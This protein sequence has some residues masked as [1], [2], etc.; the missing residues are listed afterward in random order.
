MSF[1]EIKIEDMNLSFPKAISAG[2]ILCAGDIDNWNGMTIGWGNIGNLW[3]KD[4]VIVYVRPQRYTYEFMEKNDEFSVNFFSKDYKEAI[5]IFGSKSGRDTD[6]AKEANISAFAIDKTVGFNEA[7]IIIKCRKI[8]YQDMDSKGFVDTSLDKWYS[9][10]YHR[11]Y[12]GEI[13][14]ILRK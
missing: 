1:E 13:E 9:G 6:K 2:A 14:K 7:D 11:V 4:V 10:D 12:I 8:A 3:G 5:K